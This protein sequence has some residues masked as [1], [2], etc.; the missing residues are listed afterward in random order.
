MR[1]VR[2]FQNLCGQK[3]LENVL[4]TTTQWS[5]VDP[6]EGQ[7]R[8]DN[9]RDKGLWGGLIGKGATLQRFHGTR[10]SGLELISKLMSK[11]LKPLHIQDELVSQQMTL[12]ETNAGKCVNEELVAQREKFKERLGSLEKRLQEAMGTVGTM[13]CGLQSLMEEQA[14]IQEKLEKVEARMKLFV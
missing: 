7:A 8:E 2:I 4:L 9:L 14:K 11:T 5:S 12:P 1:S 6:V 13:G 10:E 3:V